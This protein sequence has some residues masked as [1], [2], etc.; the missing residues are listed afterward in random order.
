MKTELAPRKSNSLSSKEME[1]KLDNAYV[2]K[3]VCDLLRIY[4][5][6]SYS[7]ETRCG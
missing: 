5:N 1:D 7:V 4:V 6:N 3:Q 2:I